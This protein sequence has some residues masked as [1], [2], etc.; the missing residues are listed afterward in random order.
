M[1]KYI[2]NLHPIFQE[3]ALMLSQRTGIEIVNDFKPKEND[4]VIVFGGHDKPYE[5]LTLQK[6][7]NYKFG[8]VIIATEQLNS[9]CY[10]HK[11]YIELLKKNIV[12][13][14]SFQISKELKL[15]YEI[16]SHSIYFFDFFTI[17][18]T[19]DFKKRPIDFFFCGMK[20]N[21]RE[22]ELN[23]LKNKYPN[24]NIEID[25]DYSY[26]TPLELMKKLKDVKYVINIP[27]YENSSMETHRIHRALSA[28]CKV[29]SLKPC[30]KYEEEAY[31][32]FVIFVNSLTDF[33][34][35]EVSRETVV[36]DDEWNK[37]ME[38]HGV[39]VI[40]HNVETLLKI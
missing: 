20:S 10:D 34:Y 23:K 39:N 27:F 25:F 38:K 19:I 7:L 9:E 14:F 2:I 3:N 11:H 33:E 5:L 8:Y 17:T 28:N 22:S 35:D 4:L 13:P 16:N 15:K 36:K 40:N 29:I 1:N 6:Q 26:T 24:A 21:L 30:Y 12:F 32:D 31:D 18:D 37:L